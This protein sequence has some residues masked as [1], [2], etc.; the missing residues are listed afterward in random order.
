M[1]LISEKEKKNIKG[2]AVNWAVLAGIGGLI[3]FVAG[4]LDGY[5]N[6][7]RCNNR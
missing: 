3:S 2:G 1:N 6:P 7:K 5:V 4:I